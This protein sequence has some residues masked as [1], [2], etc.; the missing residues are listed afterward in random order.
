M[1]LIAAEGLEATVTPVDC[2]AILG[3][4]GSLATWKWDFNGLGK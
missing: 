1:L 2:A 3:S 4:K